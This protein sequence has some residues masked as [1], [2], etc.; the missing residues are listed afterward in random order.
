MEKKDVETLFEKFKQ[1][2]D[3]SSKR[4]IGTGLGLWITKE[5]IELLEGKI[6]VHSAKEKGT[7]IV[8]MLKTKS[9][10]QQE[11][12]LKKQLLSSDKADTQ[13]TNLQ[14]Q[15]K[16]LVVEDIPYNQEINRKFLQKCN[17]LNITI[18]SN[19]QEAVDIVKRMGDHYFDL[20]LMDIDMPVLDGKSATKIIRYWEAE[21]GWKA[22]NIVFL[23]AYSESK[24]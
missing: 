19:G 15:K 13:N 6:E 12:I 1:V 21:N 16:V 18:A 8:I 14:T 9:S 10:L 2:H 22:A 4:Q 5:I 17:V 23:T 11:E 3:S 24:T 7:A 20:I